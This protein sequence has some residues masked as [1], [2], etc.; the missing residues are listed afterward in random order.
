MSGV[1]ALLIVIMLVC[2]AGASATST[3]SLSP[4]FWVWAGI[5]AQL[6][7]RLLALVKAGQG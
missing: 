4:M 6:G 2:L 3:I 5:C 1:T 7:L